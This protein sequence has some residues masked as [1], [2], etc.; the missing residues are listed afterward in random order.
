MFWLLY[1]RTGDSATPP[2]PGSLS[3]LIAIVDLLSI[4]LSSYLSPVM[5]MMMMLMK[6]LSDGLFRK[7]RGS[8]AEATSQKSSVLCRTGISHAFGQQPSYRNPSSFTG[9]IASPDNLGKK[10]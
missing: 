4:R 3:A 2:S 10:K 6:A 1:C 5:V 9:S 7:I 8:D